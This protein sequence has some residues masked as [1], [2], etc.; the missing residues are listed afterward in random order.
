MERTYLKFGSYLLQFTLQIDCSSYLFHFDGR[1]LP[2]LTHTVTSFQ[3]M[4]PDAS[5][6]AAAF[7]VVSEG[8]LIEKKTHILEVDLFFFA[9]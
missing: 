7:E 3:L 6:G 5:W 2:V 9:T 4:W 8:V 1:Q